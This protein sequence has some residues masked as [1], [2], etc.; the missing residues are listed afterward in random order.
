MKIPNNVL[1]ITKNN[2]DYLCI[3]T[4]ASSSL[5][6]TSLHLPHHIFIHSCRKI[7]WICCCEMEKKWNR[8][9]WGNASITLGILYNV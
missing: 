4:N 7:G 2:I 6:L 3:F 5:N 9:S 8:D 1:H